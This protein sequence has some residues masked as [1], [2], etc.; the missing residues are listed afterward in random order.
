MNVKYFKI[1]LFFIFLKLTFSQKYLKLY[2]TDCEFNPEYIVNGSC[3]LKMVTRESFA[4]NIDYDVIKEM[5]NITMNV[6]FYRFYS[7]FRPY[8]FEESINLCKALNTHSYLNG[9]NY[10]ARTIYRIVNKFSNSV[11]CHH[12]VSFQIYFK[13]YFKFSK[14]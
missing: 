14:F 10:Y 9:L 2:K 8:L 1:G 7:Q 5:K 4:A 13:N 12:K 11:I 3:S 6:I